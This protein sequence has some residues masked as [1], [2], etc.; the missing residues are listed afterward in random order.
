[1]SNKP[2]HKEL[3]T[4]RVQENLS[5]SEFS[6]SQALTIEEQQKLSDVVVDIVMLERETHAN[7]KPTAGNRMKTREEVLKSHVIGVN[8]EAMRKH[9]DFFPSVFAAMETYANNKL[10][11]WKAELREKLAKKADY[12]LR[13]SDELHDFGKANLLDRIKSERWEGGKVSC[14]LMRILK[15]C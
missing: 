5:L 13:L 2:T 6:E 10:E 9:H 15:T 7:N 12:A 14:M 8:I 1:M 4:T 11:E 3:V